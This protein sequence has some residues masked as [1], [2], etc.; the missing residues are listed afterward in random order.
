MDT[1]TATVQSVTPGSDRFDDLVRVL[2]GAET[3]LL[4]AD[5]VPDPPGYL[6]RCWRTP[7]TRRA[8][9]VAVAGQQVVGAARVV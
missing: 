9:W 3:E 8:G 4:G 1:A 7:R 2:H 5:A 6:A